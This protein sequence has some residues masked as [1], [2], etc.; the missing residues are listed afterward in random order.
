VSSSAAEKEWLAAADT[1]DML[2]QAGISNKNELVGTRAFAGLLRTWSE[3]LLLHDGPL[4]GAGELQP[5]FWRAKGQ[6]AMSIDWTT[7]DIEARGYQT[8]Q[9]AFGVRFHRKDVLAMLPPST[10]PLK[11]QP[12]P[13]VAELCAPVEVKRASAPSGRPRAK[14]WNDWIAAVACLVFEGRLL[15]A[16]KPA[17][18]L[19]AI[20]EKLA[21]WGSPEM[22]RSTVQAAL[23]QVLARLRASDENPNL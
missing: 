11:D 10:L 13:V 19:T 3:G 14:E 6:A 20:N 7:G 12:S 23:D 17:E 2:D 1:W 15:P 5:A 21:A 9:R 16:M 22:E 8:S 18:A 4:R